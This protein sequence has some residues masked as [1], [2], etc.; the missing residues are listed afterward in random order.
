MRRGIQADGQ[1]IT[2][3]DA[4]QR[5]LAELGK[6]AKPLAI[7]DFI[8]SKFGLNME[9]QL[10]SNY[11]SAISRK[12]GKQGPVILRPAPPAASAG[13][14]GGITVDDIRAV[15]EVVA[16]IG[17]DQVRQLTEVLAR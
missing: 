4:V 3:W 8:K 17:A 9:S 1:G 5:A 10:I 2:K 12:A 15:K 7:K 6:D 13:S 14:A 16:R 11:K